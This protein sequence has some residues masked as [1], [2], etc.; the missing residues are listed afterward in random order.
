MPLYRVIERA[1]L[2]TLSGFVFNSWTTKRAVESLLG[3]EIARCLVAPPGGDRF[4]ILVGEEAIVRRA[5][6]PGPFRLLFVGNV[7]PRKGLHTVFEALSLLQE[8]QWELHVAGD[9]RVAKYYIR[10]L[11]TRMI[12]KQWEKQVFFHGLV[13]DAQLMAWA[14]NYHVL[15]MPSSY[16]GF[17]IAYLEG[18]GFGLPAIGTTS[19]AAKE[20]ITDGENGFLIEPGDYHALAD[21][22]RELMADRDKLAS[23]SL[24][25]RRKFNTQ[26]GWNKRMAAIRSFLT[27]LL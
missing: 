25:A 24:R 17:G 12:Q 10:K 7:I 13:E 1:Y 15:V 26:P 18:M 9:L 8:S 2:R 27:C 23:M 4:P 5:H 19:G 20:I 22:L 16:E 21:R 3:E 6:Q 14:M 11:K